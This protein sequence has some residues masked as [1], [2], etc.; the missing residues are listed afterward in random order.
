MPFLDRD[1][2]IALLDQLGD[3][4]DTKVLAAAR[5]IHRRMNDAGLNWG[6]LLLPTGGDQTEAEPEAID[7]PLDQPAPAAGDDTALIGRLLARPG[8]SDDTRQEIEDLRA[9]IASGVF[10]AR[11]RKYLQALEARL[12]RKT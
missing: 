11:D 12:G 5:D 8:L 6:D 9:D 1:P 7:P 3:S 10:T 2:F 4:D